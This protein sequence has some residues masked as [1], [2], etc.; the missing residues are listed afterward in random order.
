MV[1]GLADTLAFQLGKQLAGGALGGPA[2]VL[3]VQATA[4][5]IDVGARLAE[6]EI[7]A[8]DLRQAQ[9]TYDAIKYQ[10]DAMQARI[11]FMVDNCAP[12]NQPETK[13]A[14]N[15]TPPPASKK[16]TG[17]TTSS[18]PARSAGQKAAAGALLGGG[19]AA[20]ALAVGQLNNMDTT[21]GSG[22]NSSKAPI[23]EVNTYCFGST[24]N[25]TLCNQYLAQY[26]T[27]CK[28]CGY[29]GFDVNQG[30]CK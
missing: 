17:T 26:D 16:S 11:Q 30:K 14:V 7:N 8:S 21:S 12:S 4:L 6:Q 27:F 15:S 13:S 20:V 28:S 3:I 25:T 18:R 29:S 2:G 1:S 9:D 24:R 22:C 23:N 5:G 19:V 10:Y